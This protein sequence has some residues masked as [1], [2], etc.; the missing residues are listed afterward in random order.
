[1]AAQV[2]LKRQQAAEDAIAG[3]RCI[4]PSRQLP[5]GPVFLE[6][7]QQAA[8]A[9]VAARR[10]KKSAARANNKNGYNNNNE[11]GG[12]DDEEDFNYQNNKNEDEELDDEN[13]G[14]GVN[15][16]S[17]FYSAEPNSLS[18]CSTRS[19]LIVATVW[20]GWFSS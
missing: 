11:D 2:A 7:E 3:L 9:A 20:T 17:Q 13:V 16:S 6:K 1:M 19:L 15:N 18:C 10:H 5:A 8:A 14:V 4:S 12:G